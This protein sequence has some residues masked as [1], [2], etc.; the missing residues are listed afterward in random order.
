MAQHHAATVLLCLAGVCGVNVALAEQAGFA[1]EVPSSAL[2]LDD[3]C[4]SAR[5][6]S[7]T[8]TSNC[9]SNALQRK[10]AMEAGTVH[11]SNTRQ[12]IDHAAVLQDTSPNTSLGRTGH[13]RPEAGSMHESLASLLTR[14][15]DEILS[16]DVS[17]RPF[18]KRHLMVFVGF[19]AMGIFVVLFEVCFLQSTLFSDFTHRKGAPADKPQTPK[20]CDELPDASTDLQHPTEDI[21]KF[22]SMIEE[23]AEK[24]VVLPDKAASMDVI[25]F[26]QLNFS[27]Y[28][29]AKSAKITLV[30]QGL[31]QDAVDV[32]VRTSTESDVLGSSFSA[33]PGTDFEHVEA[34]VRFREG[35]QLQ[36]LELPIHLTET[37]WSVSRWYLVELVEVVSGKARLG[38]P[39]LCRWDDDCG[40]SHH[41]A[42]RVY[43]LQEDPFPLNYPEKYNNRPFLLVS[44]YIQDRMYDRGSKFWKTLLGLLYNPI[45]HVVVTGLVQKHTID[46]ACDWSTAGL[47][48]Y[49]RVL[50]MGAV[51][52]F[53]FV[54]LRWGDV[55]QTKNR[56]RTGGIRMQH[57]GH[58][59]EKLLMLEHRELCEFPGSR[60]Y[61]S[62]LQNVDVITSDGYWQALVLCQSLFALVISMLM[63]FTGKSAQSGMLLALLVLPITAIWI[64]KRQERMAEML[65]VRMDAEQVWVD[66]L[67]WV[68]HAGPGLYSLGP[69]EVAHLQQK[70]AAESAYFIKHHQAARDALNDGQWISTWLGGIAYIFVLIHGAIQL[71]AQRQS[72]SDRSHIGSYVLL[73]KLMH[74]FEKYLGKM[75][76]SVV[77]LQSASVSLERV[78]QL[79]N[80]TEKSSLRSTPA[81]TSPQNSIELLNVQFA[82]PRNSMAG[83]IL[84]PLR[85][86][87]GKTCSVPLNQVVCVSG[88]A[89]GTRNSFMALLSRVIQPDEGDVCIPSATWAVM[90]PAIPSGIPDVS[91]TEALQ[92][93]GAPVKVAKLFLEMLELPCH[94]RV[95]RLPPGQLQMVAIL[96]GM[97]RDPAALVMVRPMAFV[98]RKLRHRL[99]SLLCVWQQGGL[100]L[101]IQSLLKHSSDDD[102]EFTPRTLVITQEDMEDSSILAKAQTHHIDLNQF[103]DDTIT[104]WE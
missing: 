64:A 42:A 94:A 11:S 10:A 59:F 70:F 79:L 43:V 23:V 63:L 3:E 74:E 57:R 99:E 24:K 14:Y 88:G 21:A 36:S 1:V 35:E 41:P 95:N 102:A 69:R 31:C 9:A 7:T 20:P 47:S 67:S 98:P 32:R 50:L 15:A 97:L 76:N 39:T 90:I 80:V 104:S 18:G 81:T 86:S 33:V 5:P 100:P 34:V 29:S 49:H 87:P 12:R 4:V 91:T 85:M 84:G 30:R 13:P 61:Y 68:A 26:Q 65:Q 6:E 58:I 55:T 44:Y 93:V 78:K 40:I 22:W 8:V 52:L 17:K 83:D 62:A 54:L 72:H 19:G 92:F 51:Q 73:L 53:S 101:I 96:R 66:T 82:S 56:G 16:S 75:N 71:L 27:V 46:W 103:L 2:V 77:K 37:T 25:G 60:W 45:H 28:E 89:E 48:G 38:G